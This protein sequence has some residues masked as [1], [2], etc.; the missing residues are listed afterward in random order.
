[1]EQILLG[2]ITSQMKH[3]TGKNQHRFSKG[4]SCLTNLIVFYGEVICSADVG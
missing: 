4:K 1:M 3:V 2:T